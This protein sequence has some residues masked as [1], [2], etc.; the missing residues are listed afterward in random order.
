MPRLLLPAL[1]FPC[2]FPFISFH[3]PSISGLPSA[4]I[5]LLLCSLAVGIHPHS[6]PVLAAHCQH[7]GHPTLRS[8]HTGAEWSQSQTRM[9]MLKDSTSTGPRSQWDTSDSAALGRHQP[10]VGSVVLAAALLL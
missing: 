10:W 1:S 4:V 6:L 2:G 8:R 3:E 9:M 5:Q 7:Q